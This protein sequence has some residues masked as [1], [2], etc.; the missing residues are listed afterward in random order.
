VQAARLHGWSKP[1][2]RVGQP[3]ADNTLRLLDPTTGK[4]I[5][6]LAGEGLWFG[7]LTWSPNGKVLAAT[8]IR[9]NAILLLDP[10]T[11]KQIRHMPGHKKQVFSLDWSPDGKTLA[12]TS[13]EMLCLWDVATGKEVRRL[14]NEEG[15]AHSP[16]WSPDGKTLASAS[17]DSTVLIWAVNNGSDN[18]SR[19]LMPS[20][21]NACWK[22]LA[23]DDATRAYEAIGTLVQGA[24]DSVPFLGD[25]L[26]PAPRANPGIARLIGDLNNNEFAIRQKATDELE[27]LG[28]S[29]ESDLRHA[30]ANADELEMQRRLKDLLAPLEGWSG[31]RLRRLRATAVLEYIGTAE[32]RKI[33]ESLAKGIPDARLT[34]EA[35]AAL[36]RLNKGRPGAKRE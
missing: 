10:S 2:A 31:E 32:A 11:G 30:L 8:S 12:S 15:R 19:R 9:D 5:G 36:E 28:E 25:R 17:D 22:D 18:S 21:L 29:A 1:A 23:G 27:K 14:S 34:Q 6:K 20:E 33:L 26:L 24:K 13:Q 16:A 35:K 7:P 3:P 4:D